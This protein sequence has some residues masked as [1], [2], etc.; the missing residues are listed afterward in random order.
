MFTTNQPRVCTKDSFSASCLKILP[1][2]SEKSFVDSILAYGN[3]Q[4]ANFKTLTNDEYIFYFAIGSMIN[5][6]SLHLRNIRPIVSYPATC[7]DHQIVFCGPNGM[8]NI[9]SALGE[10][11]EGVVHLLTATDMDT[12]DKVEL[13]YNRIPVTVTDYSNQTQVTYAYQIDL[14][15]LSNLEY[16]LPS[17]RYMDIIIKGCEYYGVRQAYIDRLKQINVVPRMK[18]SE[19]KCIT[20]VPDVHYTLDD[21]VLRNGTNNYPVWISVNHKIFEHTGLPSPDDPSYNQLSTT[22]NLIR[23]LHAGKDMTLKISQNIYEPL[24]GIPLT[25]DEMTLEHRSMAEDTFL[26]FI[27]NPKLGDK[28]YWRPIGKLI[29]SSSEKCTPNC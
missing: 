22:Y 20:D 16:S 9:E 19:Y 24:Y 6:I 3:R 13:F 21:L 29:K 28:T 11:L 27:S 1:A 7:Y 17:E 18:P 10:S 14:S 4:A 8:A 5:P 15:R 23:N 2:P 25:E 12:L 26:T